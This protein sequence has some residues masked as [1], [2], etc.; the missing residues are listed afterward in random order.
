MR[1]FVAA[2]ESVNGSTFRARFVLVGKPDPHNPATIQ[3][4]ELEQWKE[5]GV[6]ELWGYCNNMD[7]VL[8]SA[9]IVV[10]PSYY[11]EGIP[12]ILIEAAAC[13]RAVITT[14]HPGCRDAIEESVTGLLVPVRDADALA[15]SI[16]CLLDDP[17]RCEEMGLAGRKRA[18]E[19]F[20]L[21]QVVAKHLRIYE[22]L[23]VCSGQ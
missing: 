19:R 11:G 2:A 10:L 20:D 17:L 16:L 22:E 4:Q 1:E 7:Q 5:H 18:E 9:T 23:S 12:K 13:G 6:V 8:A 15:S 14:D 3:Q 21:R